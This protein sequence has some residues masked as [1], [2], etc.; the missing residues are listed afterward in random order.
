MGQKQQFSFEELKRSLVSQPTLRHFDPELPIEIHTDASTVRLGAVLF[1]KSVNGMRTA[2]FTSRTLSKA[3]RNYG[4]TQLEL[5][6]V[7]FGIDK[8]RYYLSGQE[9]F[10]VVTD[11]AAIGPPLRTRDPGGRLAQWIVRLGEYVFN[12]VYRPGRYNVLADALSRY[13]VGESQEPVWNMDSAPLFFASLDSI[14]EMQKQDA[15]E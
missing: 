12:V 14:I 2:A 4:I 15:F 7:V 11:H 3:Q 1:Q 6:A 10:T 9:K 8:F 13:P 5:L